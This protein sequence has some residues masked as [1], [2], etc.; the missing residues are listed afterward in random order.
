MQNLKPLAGRFESYLVAN[1]EDRFSHDAA[2]MIN[3]DIKIAMKQRDNFIVEKT[4][5]SINTGGIKLLHY[6][7]PL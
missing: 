4:G 5:T 3:D 1:P 2:P 7:A 6:F